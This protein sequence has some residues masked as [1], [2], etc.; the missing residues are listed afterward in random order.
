MGESLWL[1]LG[2]LVASS[3]NQTF[4]MLVDELAEAL[5]LGRSEISEVSTGLE[6]E[7][8]PPVLSVCCLCKLWYKA[9]ASV[10]G[11]KKLLS[12]HRGGMLQ[13]LPVCRTVS[14]DARQM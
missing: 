10:L 11:R 6:A 8:Q 1:L 12:C 4:P 5:V 9:G 13:C 14:S 3:K 2:T 7:S